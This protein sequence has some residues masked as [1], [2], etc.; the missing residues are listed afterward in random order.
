MV[1]LDSNLNFYLIEKNLI[2][3]FLRLYETNA[4]LTVYVE[5]Y[6]IHQICHDVLHHFRE[7]VVNHLY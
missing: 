1:N 5:I 3:N 6:R 4:C 2:K 7:Y